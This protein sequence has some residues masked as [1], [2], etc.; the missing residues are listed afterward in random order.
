MSSTAL[1]KSNDNFEPWLAL[2]QR[3]GV[4]VAIWS[5]N[6]PVLAEWSVRQKRIAVAS[7]S[8]KSERFH[9]FSSTILIWQFQTPA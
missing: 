2:Q 7:N 6:Q 9:R 5:W 3:N 4:N 8:Q 1:R